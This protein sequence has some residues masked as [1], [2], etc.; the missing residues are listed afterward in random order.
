MSGGQGTGTDA[1]AAGRVAVVGSLHYDILVTGGDRPRKG[2]TVF[3][4]AWAWKCGGKGGNQAIEAARHGAQTAFVGAVGRDGFGEAM[5]GTLAA[6]GVD[7]SG[8]ARLDGCGSGMSVAIFDPGGDYGAVIVPGSN[9]A[10]TSAMLDASRP[11]ATCDWLLLQNEVRPET[12]LH[13]ARIAKSGGARVVLNA[14]PARDLPGDLADLLDL[15][16]VNEIEAEM[17]AGT[18]TVDGV[19]SARAAAAA[20]VARVPRVIVTLGG[21]GLVIASRDAGPVEIAGHPVRVESTHGAGD[22]FIGALAARLAQGAPLETA[23]RYGNAAA[24]A[25][26]ATPESGRAHLTRANTLGLLDKP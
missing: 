12:N 2:E 3:G 7:T 11:L 5:L 13:A 17:L 9:W 23:A 16:V 19:P 15:L 6:A 1:G 4:K 25:L 20:L 26:V 8:I 24:A 10:I 21:K 18:G 14:A 22:A